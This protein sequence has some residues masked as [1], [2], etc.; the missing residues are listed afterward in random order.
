[1]NMACQIG[2]V[3]TASLTPFLADQYGWT[4]SFQTAAGLCLLGAVAWLFVD[5]DRRLVARSEAPAANPLA[6]AET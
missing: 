4:A 1:M 3:V 6:A 2:G 5:P